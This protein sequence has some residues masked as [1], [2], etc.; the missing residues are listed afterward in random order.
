MNEII[1]SAPHCPQWPKVPSGAF[2]CVGSG[3][4]SVVQEDPFSF[5]HPPPSWE[6]SSSSSLSITVSCIQKTYFKLLLST[7]CYDGRWTHAHEWECTCR[8]DFLGCL[9]PLFL[10]VLFSCLPLGPKG[11]QAL[12]V[13]ETLL[14]CY[15]NTEPS[16]EVPAVLLVG[17]LV[18]QGQWGRN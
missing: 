3:G 10:I 8:S 15:I 11:G 5:L 17:G 1:P 4:L 12:R 14:P 16:S 7:Q 2:T 18:E 9:L 6:S 13:L